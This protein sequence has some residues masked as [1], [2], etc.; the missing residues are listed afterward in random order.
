M[1]DAIRPEST[2]AL[3]G[4]TFGLRPTYAALLAVARPWAFRR[5]KDGWLTAWMV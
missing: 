5:P 1:T 3:D 4:Q 2:I